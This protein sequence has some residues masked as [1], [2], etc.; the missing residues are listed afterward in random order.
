MLATVLRNLL[1][2]AVTYAPAG[3]RVRVRTT[4]TGDGR[5][6]LHVANPRGDLSTADLPKLF[7]PFWRGDAVRTSDG[8]GRVGLGLA[9]VQ[10]YCGA[11]DVDIAASLIDPD[12]LEMT[13]TF[14]ASRSTAF[15]EESPSAY[16]AAE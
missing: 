8:G 4:R 6:S 5:W 10:A 14:P 11:M 7:E 9:L 3:G 1:E 15:A 16:A 2:N 13:L 12:L